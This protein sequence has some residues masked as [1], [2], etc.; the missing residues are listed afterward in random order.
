MFVECINLIFKTKLI[1][2]FPCSCYVDYV[3]MSNLY[4][5]FPR[6]VPNHFSNAIKDYRRFRTMC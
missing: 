1:D 2:I 4:R 3:E 5:V 6:I